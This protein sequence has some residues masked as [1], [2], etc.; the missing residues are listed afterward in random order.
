MRKI[1]TV[2]AVVFGMFTNVNA[3]ENYLKAY[4]Q[5]KA[6]ADKGGMMYGDIS[7]RETPFTKDPYVIHFGGRYLMYY[8]IPP[9]KKQTLIGYAIGIA[10]SSDLI[11]WKRIGEI[12]PEKEGIEKKGICAPG[13][14]VRNGVVHIFYQTYGNFSKDA[15]C[16]ATSTDGVNFKRNPTN[17]IFRPDGKWNNGRAIDAEVI[18]F[19]GKYHLYYA[20]RDAK[21]KIQMQ[22]VATAPLNTDFSRQDWTHISTDAPILKPELS[23]EQQCIEAAACVVKDD[24]L[25]MFYA[26]AYN[27]RPQQIGIAVSDDGINFKRVS[28]EPFLKN[29]SVDAWNSS[30][31]GHPHVFVSPKGDTYLFY[32]GNN[33]KGKSYFISNLKIDFKDGCWQIVK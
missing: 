10:E 12:L 11:N 14:L 18:E 17:P 4:P 7:R 31:S 21:G 30:E 6:I 2:I 29:G 8:T 26:G 16:H 24:R 5:A 19:K 3:S 22:G 33:D 27:N 9:S 15:I 28:K 32:Q 13:L 23:W 20:T 25:Y 1:I